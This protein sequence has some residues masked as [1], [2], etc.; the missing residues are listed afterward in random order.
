MTPVQPCSGW[1]RWGPS[2]R[3]LPCSASCRQVSGRGWRSAVT[4]AGVSAPTVSKVPA[5]IAT[6]PG[7]LCDLW[8]TPARRWFSLSNSRCVAAR[9]YRFAQL[10]VQL[11]VLVIARLPA[12]DRTQLLH[13]DEQRHDVPVLGDPAVDDQHGVDRIEGHMPARSATPDCGRA[14]DIR[15][16]G[17]IGGRLAGRPR[18]SRMVIIWSPDLDVFAVAAAGFL[19]A[20]SCVVDALPGQFLRR[21][22]GSSPLVAAVFRTKRLLRERCSATCQRRRHPGQARHG[23]GRLQ[24]NRCR[25]GH[26]RGRVSPLRGRRGVAGGWADGM[27]PVQAGRAA[28]RR[29]RWCGALLGDR[30]AAVHDQV[31]PGDVGRAGAGQPGNCGGDLV[32]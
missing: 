1:D 17:R 2:R 8:F 5:A 24:I 15:R 4:R 28:A 6:V 10:A 25:Y 16:S 3:H 23:Q 9:G 27:V 31:L 22:S 13:E 19:C 30:V 20:F 14:H 32:G 18:R 21:R 29:S 11:S 12:G 7:R 26:R